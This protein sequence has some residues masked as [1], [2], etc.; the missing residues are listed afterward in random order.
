MTQDVNGRADAFL[1]KEE[2]NDG[3]GLVGRP[4]SGANTKKRAQSPELG[5]GTIPFTDMQRPKTV[6]MRSGK[7]VEPR[8]F[9]GGG[10]GGGD[11]TVPKNF[12]YKQRIKHFADPVDYPQQN[13]EKRIKDLAKNNITRTQLNPKVVETWLN[14]TLT[15]AGHLEIPGVI[16]QPE[17]KK[18]LERYKIGI[19]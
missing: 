7:S 16:L 19:N 2:P 8:G 9:A 4:G 1:F 15:D 5:G 14:E 13:Y 3:A 17:S 6:K 12:A 10:I 11:Q 18:P